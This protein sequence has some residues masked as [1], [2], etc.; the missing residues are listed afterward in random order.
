[1][2]GHAASCE[3]QD[4]EQEAN[5]DVDKGVEHGRGVSHWPRRPGLGARQGVVDPLRN[6]SSSGQ[7]RCCGAVG[8]GRSSLA[9]PTQALISR[10]RGAFARFLPAPIP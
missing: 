7:A 2:S 3:V 10:D 5:H 8:R 9:F 6:R 1:M 4:L